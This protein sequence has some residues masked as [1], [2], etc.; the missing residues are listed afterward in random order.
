MKNSLYQPFHH[1]IEVLFTA[2]EDVSAIA[3]TD[4]FRYAL[5]TF[6]CNTLG[7]S[8]RHSSVIFDAPV[9]AEPADPVPYE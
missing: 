7:K 3:N 5:A 6:L 4:K 2:T 9:D 8:I 1:R